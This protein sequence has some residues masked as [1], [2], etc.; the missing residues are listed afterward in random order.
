MGRGIPVI[1]D[2]IWPQFPSDLMSVTIVLATQVRGTVLF[3]EKLYE[4]RMYCVDRLVAMGANAVICDPHRA[5]IAGPSGLHGIVLQSPD[6]RAG[7][8]LLGA[9][10]CARGESLIRNA[11][12]IDRGY[13]RIEEKLRALG[14]D[15]G[16]VPG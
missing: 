6:I 11:E 12:S 7:I 4:S 13:E 1:D 3:F 9:A 10:L 14:A 5:V 15:I 16:R 2:G 8:A